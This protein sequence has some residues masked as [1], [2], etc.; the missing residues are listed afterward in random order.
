MKRILLDM[1]LAAR[2]AM[3]FMENSTAESFRS[4]HLVQNAVVRVL[5]VLGETA[6]RISPEF[7]AQ[8]S[9]IP[10][11][12]IVALRHRLVHDYMNIDFAIVWD[13]V[14]QDLGPLIQQ[15]EPLVPREDQV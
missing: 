3:T 9:E 5:Q 4:D 11:A 15:L 14:R 8:H 10:W 13:V 1:L 2:Q 12:Q 7:K 6:R